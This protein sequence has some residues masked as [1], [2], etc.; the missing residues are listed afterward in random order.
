MTDA[1]RILMIRELVA[2]LNTKRNTTEGIDNDD[3]NYFV[4]D[5]EVALADV[6]VVDLS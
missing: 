5:V 1:E 3:L 6:I 2:N 4:E